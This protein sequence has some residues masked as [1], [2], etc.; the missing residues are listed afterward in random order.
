VNLY[1]AYR[2]RK[3]MFSGFYGF[4]VQRRRDTGRTY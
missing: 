1:S 2:L 3:A 4:S